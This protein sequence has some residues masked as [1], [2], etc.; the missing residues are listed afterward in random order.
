[1]V[2]VKVKTNLKETGKG[3]KGTT[4][5][6]SSICED[7]VLNKFL[8]QGYISLENDEVEFDLTQLDPKTNKPKYSDFNKNF[9]FKDTRDPQQTKILNKFHN[10]A[11]QSLVGFVETEFNKAHPKYANHFKVFFFGD[12]GGKKNKKTGKIK[13]LGG[14]AKGFKKQS[15]V[16][17][18]SKSEATVTHELLHAIGLRHTFD[19]KA[20]YQYKKGATYNIMDYSHLS[21][22]GR[23]NRNHIWLWQMKQL[24]ENKNLKPE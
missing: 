5:N 2:F 1:M 9:S 6:R 4:K 3:K 21:K 11:N 15:V 17:F 18:S 14:Y 20:T 19:G 12:R 10:S 22:Y 8:K 16:A 7:E 13:G 23:K 24:W